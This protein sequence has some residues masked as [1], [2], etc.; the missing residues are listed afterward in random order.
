MDDVSSFSLSTCPHALWFVSCCWLPP[1]KGHGVHPC[2]PS[3][4][5]QIERA[6]GKMGDPNSC[7]PSNC[8]RVF[9]F[10]N[11]CWLPLSNGHG[12]HSCSLSWWHF[13]VPFCNSISM[14]GGLSSLLLVPSGP[15]T[16]SS[17]HPRVLA[18]M[19]VVLWLP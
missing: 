2:G 15:S 17:V 8:H 16:V 12:V 19:A 1:S 18:P 5:H 9:W 6:W 13:T 4:W 14:F 10:L 3:W 7:S 11:C